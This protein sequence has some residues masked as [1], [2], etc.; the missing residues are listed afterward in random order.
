MCG[1]HGERY[2]DVLMI[3]NA[4]GVHTWTDLTALGFPC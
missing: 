1:P 2:V 4:T 3:V